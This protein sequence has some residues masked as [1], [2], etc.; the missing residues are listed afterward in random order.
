MAAQQVQ[1]AVAAEQWLP[2]FSEGGLKKILKIIMV[3][4][5]INTS[6]NNS[7]PSE[8]WEEAALIIFVRNPVLGKVK[9]RLA[10]SIG[11]ESTLAVY[12]YL[13][14]HT[15]NI[16]EN[17]PAAKY[18]FYADEINND[19][20]WNGYEKQ[21]QSGNDLGE[22]MTNAF[23]YLFKN[24]YKKIIIIGSDCLDLTNEI[25]NS[26][27][28]QLENTEVIIGPAKDGGYYLLGMMKDCTILFSKNDWGTNLVYENTLALI[29][30]NRFRYAN[31]IML[32]DVDTVADLPE[33][34]IIEKTK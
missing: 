20:M 29:N 21:L 15:K 14:Q 13:L 31:L 30:E 5:S 9:T 28:C 11:N 23:K 24:G 25:L 4:K 22:R 7:F 8:G 12:K 34:F 16:C 18:V 19:D 1:A 2:E 17:L 3:T 6:N 32:N 10:A 26:A 33:E 27:F